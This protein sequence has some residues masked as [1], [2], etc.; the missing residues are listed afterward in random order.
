MSDAVEQAEE[1]PARLVV[2]ISGRGSNCRSILRAIE[3]GR[4]RARIAAVVSDRPQA[5]GLGQ[6]AG[7]GLDTVVCDRRRYPDRDGFEQALLAA[8]DGFAPDWL[9]LAGFMR[10]LGAVFVDRYAGRLVNIHP[11]LLPAYRGLD[12]HRRVIEAGEREHG[13]S[14]HF[15]IPRLDAGPVISQARIAVG[16]DD[17]P[18]QLAERLLSQEHRLY[19]ATLALL[20][21]HRVELADGQIH[22]DNHRLHAPLLLGRDLDDDGHLLDDG[23]RH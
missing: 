1:E 14:V 5:A 21:N 13:A 4:L 7:A 9:V 10:V 16:P 23:L 22:I 3:H 12:T 18:D 20:L 19:P 11:S 15:V 6:A 2:L 8:I 17:S